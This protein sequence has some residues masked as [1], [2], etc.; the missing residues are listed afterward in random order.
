LSLISVRVAMEVSL[1]PVSSP[2]DK[3]SGAR[4]WW[5]LAS[6]ETNVDS[7]FAIEYLREGHHSQLP[8]SEEISPG[9]KGSGK[10]EGEIKDA[11][12]S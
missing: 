7:L 4:P 10:S 1:S 3:G 11:A 6:L 5:T 2:G 12:D 9:R 8:W